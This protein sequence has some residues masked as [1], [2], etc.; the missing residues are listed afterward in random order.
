MF[1]FL[2]KKQQAGGCGLFVS[3]F[4]D[5]QE[6]VL[7]IASKEVIFCGEE[8]RVIDALAYMLGGIRRI[9]VVGESMEIKG[10]VSST[11]VLDFIGGGDKH[12]LFTNTGL[13]ATIKKI[14]SQDVQCV[15]ESDSLPVALEIFKASGKPIHPVA[16]QRKLSAVVS[17]SDLVNIISKPTGVRVSSIM[18]GKPITA[19]ESQ[20]VYDVA[21]MMCRGPYRRLPVAK[22]GIVTGI[23]TPHDILA[24]LNRKEA[25]NMLNFEHTPVK[26]IM[27]KDV[28]F[29]SPGMDVHE[30]VR[31]MKAKKVSGMPVM[32]EDMNLVGMITK[33]DIIRAM[34]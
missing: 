4:M 33:K 25:L 30:V 22:N 15:L 21:R 27:N 2:R 6:S 10:I 1:E 34:S 12:K 13:S 24:H 18:S 16:S 28:A 17:E 7:K 14:M 8:D 32:D 11:D 29:A 26:E 3:N 19:Q 23:V 31:E 20:S 9:P 5:P